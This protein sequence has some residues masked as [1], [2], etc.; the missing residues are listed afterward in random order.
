MGI[1][2]FLATNVPSVVYMQNSGLGNAINPI[3]SLASE[4]IYNI[5]MFLIIGWRGRPGVSDEPQHLK[6][7]QITRQMLDCLN[8]P[9]WTIENGDDLKKIMNEAWNT[10]TK[11]SAPVALLVPLIQLKNTLKLK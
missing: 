7:G 10:M 2:S 9:Y 3:V 4:E 11:N 1:G 6:Q 5:P 8:V